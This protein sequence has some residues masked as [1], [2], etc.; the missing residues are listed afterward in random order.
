[1]AGK[2]SHYRDKFPVRTVAL[3]EKKVAFEVCSTEQLEYDVARLDK[4]KKEL[5]DIK[6]ENQIQLDAATEVLLQRWE[7]QGDT[8]QVKRE[9][10]GMLSRV[11]DIHVR[12]SDLDAFKQWAQDNNMTSIIKEQVNA[13]TLTSAV[14]DLLID[15]NPIPDGVSIFSKS[16]IRA[17]QPKTE[18]TE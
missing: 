6:S 11:D 4:R 16:R 8:Q 10:L 14:K 7:E 12:V 17:T 1:M 5:D 3:Q 15:G 18:E 9:A 13:S 2:W